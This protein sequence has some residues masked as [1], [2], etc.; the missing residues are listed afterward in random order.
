MAALLSQPQ[1]VNKAKPLSGSE[2]TIKLDMHE[3]KHVSF[4][5]D[6]ELAQLPLKLG[7][8]KKYYI[9]QKTYIITD[10]CLG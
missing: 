4:S 9:P 3:A 1:Y 2:L 5:F 6:L 10:P 8:W 7:H